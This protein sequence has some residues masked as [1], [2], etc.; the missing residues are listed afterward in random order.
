VSK[1]HSTECIEFGES[2]ATEQCICGNSESARINRAYV[3]GGVIT[4]GAI[5]HHDCFA[6][7]THRI[8]LQRETETEFVGW[9]DP[10]DP[11]CSDQ[12]KP[13]ID[14]PLFYPKFA[15]EQR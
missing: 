5:D 6:A 10:T 2:R 3:I 1:R 7:N 12:W 4:I 9:P 14:K 11:H 8:I 15:W 13:G